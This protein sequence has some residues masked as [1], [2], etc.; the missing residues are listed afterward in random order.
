MLYFSKGCSQQMA[1]HIC[2]RY[3]K[4]RQKVASGSPP[5]PEFQPMGFRINR[6]NPSIFLRL[7]LLSPVAYGNL[8]LDIL[9]PSSRE[10][11]E[12]VLFFCF[13]FFF[14]GGFGFLGFWFLFVVFL[15]PRAL[16]FHLPLAFP[17]AGFFFA[18][19]PEEGSRLSPM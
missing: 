17:T 14:G 16:R 9:R 15:P 11:L 19:G 2:L 13:V 4:V 1:G 7:C 3:T 5:N 10:Q 12:E 6:Q 18:S 8:S